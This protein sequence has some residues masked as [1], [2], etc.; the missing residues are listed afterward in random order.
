[1]PVVRMATLPMVVPA[2]ML[3][4]RVWVAL[5]GAGV[6]LPGTQALILPKLVAWAEAG[7]VADARLKRQVKKA[8]AILLVRKVGARVLK[9]LGSVIGGAPEDLQLLN[10][11]MVGGGGFSGEKKS[12]RG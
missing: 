10:L 12:S 11:A 4:V 2:G 7:V 3:K 9:L 8:N 6:V 1:M 5:Q